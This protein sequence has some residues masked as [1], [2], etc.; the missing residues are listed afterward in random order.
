MTPPRRSCKESG[1]FS[2][3]RRVQTAKE[4]KDSKNIY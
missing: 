1:C 2:E 4:E 3:P